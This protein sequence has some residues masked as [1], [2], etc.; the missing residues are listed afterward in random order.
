MESK[1]YSDFDKLDENLQVNFMHSLISNDTL[2]K[3]VFEVYPY[4]TKD[5]WDSYLE[6][7]FESDFRDDLQNGVYEK[8]LA[9]YILNMPENDN[10]FARLQ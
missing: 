10:Q 2:G 7:Y 5:V 3:R 6:T 8:E 1:Y 9:D 4:C